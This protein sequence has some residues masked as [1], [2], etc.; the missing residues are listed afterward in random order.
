V[1]DNLSATLSTS[2]NQTVFIPK[3]ASFM[4]GQGADAGSIAYS[5]TVTPTLRGQAGGNSVPMVMTAFGICSQ[6]SNAML[7]PN[8]HSG[9]YEAETSRTLDLNCARPDCN[10]GGVAVVA[11]QGS[12][13]GRG[14]DSGPRVAAA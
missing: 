11:V 5:E 4:G 13:I 7:S 1:Q 14:D 8:P 6:G 2:N 9:I 10:Q 3:S 12:M